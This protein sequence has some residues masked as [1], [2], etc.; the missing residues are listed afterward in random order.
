MSAM[1]FKGELDY[2]FG[3]SRLFCLVISKTTRLS[4]KVCAGHEMCVSFV[5]PT[6]VRYTSRSG[7]DAQKRSQVF[8][9]SASYF[10]P[11]LAQNWNGRYI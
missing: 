6:L 5:S 8:L 7:R 4:E 3:S 9:Y 1:K 10:C 2:N 11:I